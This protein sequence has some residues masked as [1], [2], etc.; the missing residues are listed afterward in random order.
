MTLPIRRK[1]FDAQGFLSYLAQQGCEIGK[2]TNGYEVVRYR[3]YWKGSKGPVTHIVYA[4]ES[5]LL[6]WMQ[7]TQEHYRAFVGGMALLFN[8]APESL[9]H[10]A[11]KPVRSGPSKSA[12]R[13]E[14][15]RVRDGDDCWFCGL[16]MGDDCTIEHLVPKSKGG[17]NNLDNYALA[18]K[19]CNA[20]AADKPLVEKIELRAKM[21]IGDNAHG[22]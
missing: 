22:R 12:V 8:K 2:P 16:P 17:G 20:A 19:A 15:L 11:A 10:V 21:R 9:P 5:G 1:D 6:T 4:K 14:T 7:G 13:R 3:A 18:H